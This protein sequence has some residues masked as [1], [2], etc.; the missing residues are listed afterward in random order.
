MKQPIVDQAAG[1]A[2]SDAFSADR[3]VGDNLEDQPCNCGLPLT[4]EML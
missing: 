2:A 3:A 1:I 4:V